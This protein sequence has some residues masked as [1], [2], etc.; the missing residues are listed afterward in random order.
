MFHVGLAVPCA[1][2]LSLCVQFAKL[3]QFLDS[4]WGDKPNKQEGNAVIN[5]AMGAEVSIVD[6]KKVCIRDHL[7][8]EN[9]ADG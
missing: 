7:E 2:P 1:C 4:L 5:I 3:D 8:S 6:P 9:K